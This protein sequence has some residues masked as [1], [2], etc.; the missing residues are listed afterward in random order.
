[1]FPDAFLAHHAAHFD[2]SKTAKFA[3]LVFQPPSLIAGGFLGG[4]IG[5]TNATKFLGP[6]INTTGL[7]FQ[8]EQAQLPGYAINTVD[9][10][11]YGS[12]WSVAANPADFQPLE[13]QFISAGDMWERKFFDDWMEYIVPKRTNRQHSADKITSLPNYIES[14]IL[15]ADGTRDMMTG[16]AEGSAK[17]RD[18]YISTIQVI[19]FHDT[20]VP[21][22]RYHFEEAYPIAVNPQPVNWGDDGI[23]R[24][25]VTFKY[26]S[27]SREKNVISQIYDQFRRGSV[28]VTDLPETLSGLI[29]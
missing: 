9:Q 27:W 24:V 15:N 16:A 19:A 11:I 26:S 2:F 25:N 20:G 29:R 10:R 13:L 1:M 5:Q 22:T 6:A 18:E 4:L 23:N 14:R 7:S 8:C 21:V 17:Y 28:T 3:V 12:P